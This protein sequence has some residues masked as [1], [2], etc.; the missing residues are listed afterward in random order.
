MHTTYICRGWFYTFRIT[1]QDCFTCMLTWK[2]SSDS[3]NVL[4]IEVIN[5]HSVENNFYRRVYISSNKKRQSEIKYQI[6]IRYIQLFKEK[7]RLK[8]ILAKQPWLLIFDLW[9]NLLYF[10]KLRWPG[11]IRLMQYKSMNFNSIR[12]IFNIYRKI[13]M[14]SIIICPKLSLNLNL[15]TK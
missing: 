14:R 6:S 10:K 5:D 13:S 1:P 2:C 12:I 15:T 11:V 3:E 9:V 7:L 8:W 4:D